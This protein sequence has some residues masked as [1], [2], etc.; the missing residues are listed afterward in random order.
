MACE[1]DAGIESDAFSPSQGN[2]DMR[3]Q[4]YCWLSMSESW[5]SIWPSINGFGG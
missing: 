5:R 1:F 2:V 4:I 3:R